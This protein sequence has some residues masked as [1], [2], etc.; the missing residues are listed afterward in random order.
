[1]RI[2]ADA[3][4]HFVDQNAAG[5]PWF[6]AQLCPRRDGNAAGGRA[7]TLGTH[8][9]FACIGHAYVQLRIDARTAPTVRRAV[10]PS[11]TNDSGWWRRWR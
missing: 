6:A 9:P 1:M 11:F 3:L 2:Y 8:F 7:Q 5:E 10:V 4:A